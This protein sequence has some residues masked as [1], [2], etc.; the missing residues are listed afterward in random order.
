LAQTKPEDGIDLNAAELG[1]I[2]KLQSGTARVQM[3]TTGVVGHSGMGSPAYFLSLEGEARDRLLR[4]ERHYRYALAQQQL[5]RGVARTTVADGAVCMALNLG[6]DNRQLLPPFL[7][8]AR[9]QDG[10]FATILRVCFPGA[11]QGFLPWVVLHQPP[12]SRPVWVLDPATSVSRV[13][14]G[15]LI[16]TLIG[17]F[18]PG[19]GCGNPRA[20]LRALGRTLVEF[21]SL[22]RDD[23]EEV[24]RL[25]LWNRANREAARLQTLLAKY[26]GEPGFWASDVQRT[27]ATLREALPAR[28]YAVPVDLQAAASDGDGLAALQQLVHRFGEL[29]VLWPDLVDAA[30]QLRRDC[31]RWMDF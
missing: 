8:I 11:C 2:K 18:L 15:H 22:A 31:K 14:T 6:L 19:P 10:V 16:Q 26:R 21:A 24:V 12:A 4:S 25:Q 23:F 20:A 7:P 30:K 29:I 27:L 9:N 3:T 17:S 28:Q 5:L 13:Q 1:F